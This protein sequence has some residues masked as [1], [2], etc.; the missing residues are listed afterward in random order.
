MMKNKQKN[1]QK[2]ITKTN[3]KLSS[4]NAPDDDDNV[5]DD[6]YAPI[7]PYDKNK[8]KYMPI[9]KSSL[10]FLIRHAEKGDSKTSAQKEENLLSNFYKNDPE[11]SDYGAHQAKE[12]GLAIMQKINNLKK[13]NKLKQSVQPRILCSPYWRCMKTALSIAEGFGANPIAENTLYIEDCLIEWQNDANNMIKNKK[14]QL[15]IDQVNDKELK[16]NFG[17]IKYQ[18]NKLFNYKKK[19]ELNLKSYECNGI[20]KKRYMSVFD[21]LSD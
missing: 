5:Q 7:E 16:K 11:I 3:P 15:I 20:I 17:K 2:N 10:F 6:R 21:N 4:T 1:T 18:R 12:T 14:G 13:E 8:P 19:Q 9:G